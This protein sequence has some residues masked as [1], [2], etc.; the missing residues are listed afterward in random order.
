MTPLELPCEYIPD[1]QC[2]LAEL[3]LP[4]DTEP[5][6]IAFYRI[7]AIA[8]YTDNGRDCTE[9]LVGGIG[10]VCVLTYEEVKNRIGKWK[11][12]S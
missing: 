7:D 4:F 11:S 12:T 1:D 9:I 3:D 10:Y 6:V 5:R 2:K 8:P